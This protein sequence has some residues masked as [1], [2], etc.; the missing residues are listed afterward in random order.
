MLFCW[1]T[2]S[3]LSKSS[4]RCSSLYILLSS[5]VIFWSTS[6]LLYPSVSVEKLFSVGVGLFMNPKKSAFDFVADFSGCLDVPSSTKPS[7]FFGTFISDFRILT[8][9][10]FWG[11][12]RSIIRSF[13]LLLNSM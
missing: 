6:L 4:K 3:F 1:L 12:V 13:F 10:L 7:E 11:F 2:S 9:P 8:A 5:S